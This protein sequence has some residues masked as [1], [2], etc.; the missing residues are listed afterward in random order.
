MTVIKKSYDSKKP[1]TSSNVLKYFGIGTI[2]KCLKKTKYT[3]YASIK[4]ENYDLALKGD[5]RW[6]QKVPSQITLVRSS[7]TAEQ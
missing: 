4:E 6:L 5:T 3:I 7:L 1:Q 2:L